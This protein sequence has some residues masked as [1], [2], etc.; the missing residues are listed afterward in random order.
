MNLINRSTRSPRSLSPTRSST[1]PLPPPPS[2]CHHHHRP[3]AAASTPANTTMAAILSPRPPHHHRHKYHLVTTTPSPP[4][5]PPK[6]AFGFDKSTKRGAVS[7]VESTIK[8]ALGLRISTTGAFGLAN[9][10]LGKTPSR[11][12]RPV[13]TADILWQFCASYSF[14]ISLAHDGS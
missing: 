12:F 5:P 14:R 3:I 13:K 11:S 8:G 4:Q 10:R 7:L 6:T 2:Y 1:P 9:N